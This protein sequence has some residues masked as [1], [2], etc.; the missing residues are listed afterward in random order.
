PEMITVPLEG[1]FLA[2]RH[3][4]EI[5]ALIDSH[6]AAVIGGGLG[7]NTETM[8][9]V[10]EIIEYARKKRTPCVIDADALHALPE[11]LAQHFVV[12]PHAMEFFT[13][14]GT[15]LEDDA[16]QRAVEA[17]KAAATLHCVVLVKGHIDVISDGSRVALD[18]EGT[19]Y[20]TKGGAG[21]VLA[22]ICGSLLSRGASSYD[23]A[24]AAAFITGSAGAA[25][26]KKY[27]ESMLAS[28]VCSEIGN[29]IKGVNSV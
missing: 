19:S 23:A 24:C 6:D 12:T 18:R 9:A 26:A 3:L 28:D 22:G 14:T 25:A 10:R 4:K 29:V 1:D 11:K 20:M 7:R 17:K 27:G 16:K 15:K 5:F 21:D 2:K 8:H 13:M